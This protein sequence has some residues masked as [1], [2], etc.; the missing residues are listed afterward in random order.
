[1][2]K[3]LPIEEMHTFCEEGQASSDSNVVT[4]SAA[5]CIWKSAVI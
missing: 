4:Y 5:K 3:D 1:M 2:E